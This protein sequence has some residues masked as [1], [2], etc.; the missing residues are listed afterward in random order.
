M[1]PQ[2]LFLLESLLFLSLPARLLLERTLFLLHPGSALHGFCS[3]LL[4]LSSEAPLLP[5]LFFPLQVEFPALPVSVLLPSL[6]QTP[7]SALLPSLLQAPLSSPH[8]LVPVLTAPSPL[9][10]ARQ[11]HCPAL[12]PVLDPAL[13]T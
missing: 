1:T 3:S 4:P 5:D 10:Q 13:Q 7:V 12:S 8:Q 2:N 9:P 11:V 6:L